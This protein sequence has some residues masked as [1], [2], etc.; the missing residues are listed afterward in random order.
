M[1]FAGSLRLDAPGP[2]ALEVWVSRPESVADGT[3]LVAD[4]PLEDR[5]EL[6]A[7]WERWG[8]AACERLLGDFAYVAY[9]PR[10][11]ALHGARDVFGARPLYYHATPQRFAFASSVRALQV[12]AG[13]PTRVDEVRLADYLVP[14]LEAADLG[15]TFF[16]GIRRLPAAHRFRLDRGGL[17]LERYWRPRP[18]PPLRLGSDAAYAE[19]FRD[20][21]DAAVRDRRGGRTAVMLSGGLDSGAVAASALDGPGALHAFS[22][23]DEDAAAGDELSGIRAVQRLPGLV[24]HTVDA[25]AFLRSLPVLVRAAE[26]SEEPFDAHM[27][28]PATLYAAARREGFTTLLDGVDG[29]FVASLEPWLVADLLRRGRLD[30][31][32]GEARALAALYREQYAPWGSTVGLLLAGARTAFVPPAAR[33]AARRWLDGA[34]GDLRVRESIL[35]P[36][37]AR[38]AGVVERLRALARADEGKGRGDPARSHAAELGH[39][40]LVVAVERYGRVAAAHGMEARHPFLD[41]RVVELCLS[42][43]WEQKLRGGVTKRIVRHACAGRLPAEVLGRRTRWE[44]LGPALLGRFLAVA[45]PRLARFVAEGLRAVE[46]F[47]EPGAVRSAW[48]AYRSGASLADGERVWQAANLA[49]WLAAAERIR[50]RPLPR[51]GSPIVAAGAR[52]EN[53][54]WRPATRSPRPRARNTASPD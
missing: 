54:P 34:R 2:A 5:A 6:R 41:R 37:L 33:R 39:P 49:A 42:L 4:C 48:E 8:A 7:T 46:E 47:V 18:G 30:L 20:A 15:A 11:R 53:P 21:F 52:T 31:A 24:P 16:H 40:F 9:D 36:E 27:L 26:R 50:M 3:W 28:L 25:A 17:T 32:L 35:R 38:R 22:A 14:P 12:L 13:A 45:T 19:A 43:P 51:P 1:S 29:D 44:R 23:V 10:R